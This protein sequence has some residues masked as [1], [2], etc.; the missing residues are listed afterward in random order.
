MNKSNRIAVL[1][2]DERQSRIAEIFAQNGK[3]VRVYGIS[4][5]VCGVTKCSSAKDAVDGC[6]TVIFPLPA[7][8][9]GSYLNEKSGSLTPVETILDAIAEGTDIY[10]GK[11]DAAFRALCKTR[12]LSLTD[13][14]DS[15]PLTVKNAHLTAEGAL[16]I[17]MTEKKTAV[18]GS[19]VLVLGSGRVA[20]CVARVFSAVGADVTVMARNKGELAMAEVAG[21]R[22]ADLT[23]GRTRLAQFAS[24]YDA[25]VN[26]VPVMFM[27][28][29]CLSVIPE[30]TL[31]IDLASVPYG[32]DVVEARRLGINAVRASSLPGKY[33]PESAA[34]IIADEISERMKYSGGEI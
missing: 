17:Y 12:E 11:T 29:C 28:G 20:K 19:R 2:G 34:R 23:D 14:Y 31:V 10:A 9:N 8:K 32:I 13:Y 5:D 33:A 26:T 7:V 21:H 15:E 27:T 4:E 16:Y 6:G 30:E 3:K 25:I 24:G 22:T 18:A 1:G